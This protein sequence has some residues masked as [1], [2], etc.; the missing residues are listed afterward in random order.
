[1]GRIQAILDYKQIERYTLLILCGKIRVWDIPR[2]VRRG[3]YSRNYYIA[4]YRYARDSKKGAVFF[5]KDL[6]FL[7]KE[8]QAT[9]NPKELYNLIGVQQMLERYANFPP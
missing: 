6:D 2:R 4:A 1:M 8:I 9:D 5:Q 3:K 7:A